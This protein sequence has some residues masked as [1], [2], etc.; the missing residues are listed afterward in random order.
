MSRLALPPHTHTHMQGVLGAATGA[1][2]IIG[3]YFAFYS[4]T[5]Q[6]LRERTELPEG[7]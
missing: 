2:I 4:T 6:F 5:K 1:G 7:W 3:A